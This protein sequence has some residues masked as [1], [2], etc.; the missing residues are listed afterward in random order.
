MATVK[1]AQRVRIGLEVDGGQILQFFSYIKQVSSDR[2]KLV[3]SPSKQHIAQYLKEGSTIRL[4]IYTPIGILLMDSIVM[5]EP[6]DFEFEVEFA[7]SSKRIQR[8][9]YIRAKANYRLILEQ[10]GNPITVLSEDI[11]GG[12]VRFMCDSYLHPATVRGKL[13]I[14]DIRDGISFIG[15]VTVKSYYKE[16]EYLVVFEDI[17]EED[18]SKIIQKCI[19]LEAKS[20]RED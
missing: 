20:I 5:S 18:R 7:E 4:S 12:G 15:R 14:P 8:R 6:V 10:T 16:K 1:A 3:F 19:Q 11:G 13:F 17:K 2:L 9:R